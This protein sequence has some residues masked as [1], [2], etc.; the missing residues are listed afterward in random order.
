[1]PEYDAFGREIGEDTLSGLGGTATPQPRPQPAPA[2]APP[3][4]GFTEAKPAEPAP[5]AFSI[6]EGAPVAVLPGGRR[7]RAGGLGCLV[8]LVILAAVVAGPVIA[9]VSFVGS[10]SDVIDD[11]TDAI[12]SENLD[13]PDISQ[14]EVA[15]PP[16]GIT[17]QSLIAEENLAGAMRKI[18]QAG[19]QRATQIAV[20]PDRLRASVVKGGRERD[21]QM[22]YE[23]G[24]DPGTARPA[25]AASRTLAISSLDPAAPTRLVRGS[26]KR[27]RVKPKGVY[28]IAGP[29]SEPGDHHWRA[30]FKNG[31]Y[32]EGD[33]KGRVIRRFDGG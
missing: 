18:E 27:Y 4:D 3:S 12:D 17:G 11:V 32:V 13:I 28:L 14:P 25:N 20:W 30:Y 8:G 6:P 26:V 9:I 23:G 19:F 24:L 22:G 16:T 29:E 5:A 10:A 7:R 1:V 21:L 33:A 31:I 2:S 15:A